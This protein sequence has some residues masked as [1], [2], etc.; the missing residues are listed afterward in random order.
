MLIDFIGI[1]KCI[2]KTSVNHDGRDTE[3]VAIVFLYHPLCQLLLLPQD[4]TI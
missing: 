2:V 1:R 4:E 3:K